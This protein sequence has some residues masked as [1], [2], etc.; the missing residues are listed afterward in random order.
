M[1]L[2]HAYLAD[3]SCV[4]A[5]LLISTM[6]ALQVRFESCKEPFA[7]FRLS[8]KLGAATIAFDKR[9]R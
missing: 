9:R 2:G 1:C 5:S 8:R 4:S 6:G 3:A 7:F